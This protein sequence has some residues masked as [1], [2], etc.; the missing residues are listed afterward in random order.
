[1]KLPNLKVAAYSALSS[2]GLG[3]TVSAASG[4]FCGVKLAASCM[5]GQLMGILPVISM[6]MVIGAGIVYAAGQMMGAETRARANTW[7]TAM[8]VGAIIGIL[9]V[10]VA[11][12]VLNVMYGGGTSDQINDTLCKLGDCDATC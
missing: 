12:T 4:G 2:L 10:V 6:L 5:C 9:I 7:A 3:S 8:L 1:M 11:P